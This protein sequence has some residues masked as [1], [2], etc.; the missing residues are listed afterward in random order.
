MRRNHSNIHMRRPI[1]IGWLTLFVGLDLYIGALSLAGCDSNSTAPVTDPNAEIA[2][3]YPVGGE[4]VFIGDIL[5]IKWK[6]QGLGLEEINAVN[7]ELSPDSGKTWVGLLTK[8]IGTSDTLWGEFPWTIPSEVKKLG[9]TYPL[10]DNANIFLKI[11]Q[12]STADKNKIVVTKKPF[13]IS[14]H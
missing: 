4:H 11:M 9:V 1:R 10:S 6:A 5:R 7:I 12:Y 2:I 3:L 8:S 14:A 13:T